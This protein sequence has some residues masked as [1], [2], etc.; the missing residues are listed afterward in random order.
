MWRVYLFKGEKP[1]FAWHW[2]LDDL[3][4]VE[5][6]RERAEGLRIVLYIDISHS[7]SVE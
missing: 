1:R 7:G 6:E 5:K 2:C 3:Q 4:S